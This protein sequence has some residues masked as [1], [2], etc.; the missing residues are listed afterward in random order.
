MPAQPELPKWV[1]SNDES[2]RRETERARA[3]TP[4]ERWADVVG[5][6]DML[7]TYWSIPGYAERIKTAVDPLPESSRK[8]LARLREVARRRGDS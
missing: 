7:R 8:H 1:V 3:M 5:A 6:C 2:V 4:Q